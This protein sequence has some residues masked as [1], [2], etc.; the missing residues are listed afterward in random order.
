MSKALITAWNTGVRFSAGAEILIF[1]TVSRPA[2]GA[3]QPPV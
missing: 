3:I 1:V 2:L